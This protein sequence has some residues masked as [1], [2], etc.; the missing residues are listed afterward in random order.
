MEYFILLAVLFSYI[1]SPKLT[2]PKKVNV[3]SIP[4]TCK[5]AEPE[6]RECLKE[7]INF[8]AENCGE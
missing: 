2:P 8:Y 7:A 1:P 4:Y 6:T 3:C 5:T